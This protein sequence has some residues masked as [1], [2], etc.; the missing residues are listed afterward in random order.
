MG[1]APPR[2]PPLPQSSARALEDGALAPPDYLQKTVASL[3][4]A[5]IFAHS[6][7]HGGAE[8]PLGKPECTRGARHAGDGWPHGMLGPRTADH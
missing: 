3:P 2:L 4:K 1:R 8:F 6:N 5:K 7:S